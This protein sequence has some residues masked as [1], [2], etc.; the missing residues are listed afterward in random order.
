MWSLISSDFCHDFPWFL[1]KRN[2]F[3]KVSHS[4][5]SNPHLLKDIRALEAI[6][7]RATRMVPKFD[8]M[9]YIERLTFLNL[10]SLYYRHKRMDMIIT[11]KIIHGLVCVPCNEFFVFNLGM[12]R[13]NGLKL[14]K[15]H[16]NT[17]VRLHCYKNR[18]INDWNSPQATI[19]HS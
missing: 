8:T 17:N 13:S 12:T 4:L 6:Q 10:P 1:G 3:P 15:E 19:L 9:T 5:V 11:Y 16:V 7:Q 14:S 18:V 2:R